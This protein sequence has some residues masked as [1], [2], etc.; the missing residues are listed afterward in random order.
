MQYGSDEINKFNKI[1]ILIK[2]QGKSHSRE[3]MIQEDLIRQQVIIDLNI[4]PKVT[5]Y[6]QDDLA[7]FKK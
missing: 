5:F 4:R 6:N 7:F 3:E 2:K 1:K